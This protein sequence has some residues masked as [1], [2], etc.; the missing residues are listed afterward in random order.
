[1]QKSLDERC[2]ADFLLGHKLQEVT[3]LGID[4]GLVELVVGELRKAVV[5]Q[6][7]FDP[8]LIQR[9]VQRL[10]VEVAVVYVLWDRVREIEEKR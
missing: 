6:V 2:V 9:Q 5:K 8:L 7:E 10:E 1:M 3:L 4:A